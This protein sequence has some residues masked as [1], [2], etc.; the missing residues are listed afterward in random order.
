[1][2][3]LSQSFVMLMYPH[4]INTF[5][6]P[7]IAN[8]LLNFCFFTLAQLMTDF[9]PEGLNAIN[10]YTRDLHEAVGEVGER[11]NGCNLGIVRKKSRSEF[12][13]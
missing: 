4:K 12:T 3:Y 10:L 7:G 11:K 5:L 6:Q 2:F 9:F 8:V 1:M 13:S